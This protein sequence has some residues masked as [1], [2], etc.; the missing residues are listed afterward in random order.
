METLHADLVVDAS[1]RGSR[2][3]DWLKTLGYA[4]PEVEIVEVGMGYAT[5]LYRREAHHFDGDLVLNISPT[6]ANPRACGMMAQEGERWIVTLAGYFGNQPPTDDAGFL[7]FAKT[8]PTREV[9]D[10]IRSATPLS[11]AVAYKFPSN[12]RRHYERLARFPAGLIVTGDAVCSFTPIYG[13]G[14]SVAAMEALALRTALAAGL[15]GLGPRFFQQSAK[16]VDMAWSI[17]VGNDRRLAA[18]KPAGSLGKRLINWYMDK[19]LVA[20]RRDPEVAWAF[21]QVAALLKSPPSV[22]HPTVAWRV[23]RDMLRGGKRA[24]RRVTQHEMAKA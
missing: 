21:M 12:Q 15:E 18:T 1:G 20:A 2:M 16:A 17:T 5:R 10:V 22:L 11:H 8:L 14:M 13:Q 23:L 6:R 4:A 24:A 7:A 3:D 9:Y 19:L